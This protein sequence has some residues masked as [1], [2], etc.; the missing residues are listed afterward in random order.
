MSAWTTPRSLT[1]VKAPEKI[2]ALLCVFLSVLILSSGLAALLLPEAPGTTVYDKKG[3]T[4]DASHSDQGYVMIKQTGVDKKLKLRISLGKQALTYDLNS[5]GEYEV[6][7]LQLG[8][9]KY[10][11]QV[12]SQASGNK[13]NTVS[14][15]SFKVKLENE[16]LPFLYPSQY[17]NYDGGSQVVQKAGELCAGLTTDEE[18]FKAV[19]QYVV[20]HMVYDYVKALTVQSGYLPNVDDTLSTNKGICFDFASMIAAMLRSQGVP[21]QVVIGYADQS[22][23]AWNMAYYNDNWMRF[24]ATSDICD[25]TVNTYTVERYY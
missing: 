24:D 21:T 9:G 10:K 20:D 15:V 12:F 11:V 16:L 18:K 3:T 19:Y 25:T 13:Y 14:S 23:H 4:V 8:D 2:A 6:F 17:V 5:S 1:G 7:P 22:Y